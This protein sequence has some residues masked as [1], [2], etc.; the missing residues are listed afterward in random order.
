MVIVPCLM[1]KWVSEGRHVL[2]GLFGAPNKR[3]QRTLAPLAPLKRESF[4]GVGDGGWR[5]VGGA[6][7]CRELASSC[8]WLEGPLIG[9]FATLSAFLL[10]VLA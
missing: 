5:S 8:R 10:T 4:G 9:I 6:I 7:R 1:V 2:R 3:L